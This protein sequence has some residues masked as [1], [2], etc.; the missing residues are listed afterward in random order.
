[1]KNQVRFA[2]LLTLVAALAVATV[3]AAQ[4]WAVYSG[5]F[6]L[7][8]DVQWGTAVLPAGEYS[9][10]MDTMNGPLSVRDA[11][12]RTRALLYGSREYP[13]ANQPTA[14]F[15]TIAGKSRMVRSL[16]CPAWGAN[17]VFKAVTQEERE[18]LADLHT[19]TIQ[20]RLASR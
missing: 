17:L 13:K 8:Y 4:G 5:R 19:E 20:V 6:T 11:S 16:N 15:V 9:L 1:M 3:G 14:L 10:A 7:P 12:G 18:R 2:L